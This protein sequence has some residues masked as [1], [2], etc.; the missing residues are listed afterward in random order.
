MHSSDLNWLLTSTQEEINQESISLESSGISITNMATSFNPTTSGSWHKNYQVDNVP[1]YLKK[2][3]YSLFSNFLDDPIQLLP[4]A[5]VVVDLGFFAEHTGIYIGDGKIV[6]LYGDGSVNTV[7]KKDFIMGGYK[8]NDFSF[9]TGLHIY[10][11]SYDGNVIASQDVANRA[12][13]LI[14]KKINYSTLK[15]NCHMLSGYCF[16]GRNFQKNTDCKFFYGLTKKIMDATL[17]KKDLDTSIFSFFDLFNT[18][19]SNINGGFSSHEID[20]FS[21]RIVE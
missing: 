12:K 17:I 19:R 2:S 4:G 14:G 8:N 15:N 1:Y 5:I 6:E 16:A 9:R 20:K 3:K 11:A 10:S 18:N 13:E 7:S 21:W